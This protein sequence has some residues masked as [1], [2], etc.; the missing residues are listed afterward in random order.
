MKIAFTSGDI[1]GI[2]IECFIKTIQRYEKSDLPK[3]DITLFCNEDILKKY[4]EI[5]PQKIDI[6][7]HKLIFNSLRVSIRSIEFK[8][9]LNFGELREDAGKHAAESIG[10]VLDEI[11]N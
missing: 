5:S 9:E 7:N 8:P 2:G 10:L 11:S 4:L 1:N 3:H 6:V